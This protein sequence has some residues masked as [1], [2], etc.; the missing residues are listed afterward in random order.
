MLIQGDTKEDELGQPIPVV[1]SANSILS[2]QQQLEHLA[3]TTAID[4]I[5]QELDSGAGEKISGSEAVEQ[6]EPAVVDGPQTGPKP[7]TLNQL[8]NFELILVDT[9]EKVEK[10][11][12]LH[13]LC[14]IVIPYCKACE[15]EERFVRSP[16]AVPLCARKTHR[17]NEIRKHLAFAK[18]LI[19]GRS[20]PHGSRL[21]M[22][23]YKSKELLVSFIDEHVKQ[24]A[25]ATGINVSV[26]IEFR[27]C[28]LPQCLKE[29]RDDTAAAS[30]HDFQCVIVMQRGTSG[31]AHPVKF[32]VHQFSQVR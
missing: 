31:R 7:A 28:T 20:S 8:S 9:L 13:E 4:G 12:S 26:P 17:F 29:K 23:F 24:G 14:L 18:D 15:V 1:A 32:K 10:C 21:S 2:D 5:Y 27:P 30:F 22:W 6:Q 11:K 3:S 16:S 19:A 25:S